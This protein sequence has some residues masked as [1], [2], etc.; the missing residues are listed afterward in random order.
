MFVFKNIFVLLF[1]IL[2]STISAQWFPINSGTSNNLNGLYFLNSGTGY[3]V[4]DAGTILKTTDAG[5]SWNI[6]TSGTSNS[7]YDA[8]FFDDNTGIVVGEGGIVRRTTNGGTDW[9]TIASGVTDNITSVSFSGAN[10][11]AGGSSQTIIYSSD[12]GVSWQIGQTGFFGGGFWGANMFNSNTGFV[13]GQNSIFQ[14]FVGKTTNGGVTWDFYNFYFQS[15]EG[16]CDDI[17]FFDTNSGVTSGILW[18][19]QGAIARTTNSGID[20]TSTIF[21]FGIQGMD[22]PT[23]EIGFA[24]GW[25][26]LIVGTTNSGLSWNEI[27]SGTTVN[28]TDVDF[29]G[30]ALN[31]IAVGE[32]GIILRTDNGG[33]PVELTSFTCSLTGNV[34]N[35]NWS[36]ATETNNQGFEIERKIND[37]WISIGFIEGHG[38]TTEIRSYTFNDNLS[39]ISYVG[40]IYYRLKQIDLNGDFEYSQIVNIE[41]NPINGLALNQ[42]YPNPFNPST[43]IEFSLPEAVDNVRLTVYNSLGEKVTE[44]VNSTLTSGSYMFQWNA[45]NVSAGIYFYELRTNNFVSMK[46][47]SLLK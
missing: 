5:L 6:L 35:L 11:V 47:M 24:V 20:W 31:G 9:T 44:L 34:I 4:G 43:V 23:L 2:N 10:G 12:S 26:G 16:R 14:P 18:D 15:N 32:G 8:Y 21:P 22:F 33:L 30:N 3:V 25:S 19:G 38:T 41:I 29:T 7:L 36:T 1:L 13:S 27:T 45:Q 17:F 37:E 42:N 40:V 28:L 46:K 39:D